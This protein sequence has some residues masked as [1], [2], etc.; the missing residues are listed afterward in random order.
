M[1]HLHQM[2]NKMLLMGI[3]S[4]WPEHAHLQNLA[5][6]IWIESESV[7]SV[8]VVTDLVAGEVATGSEH[9]SSFQMQL[10]L[11]K[12]Q[13]WD[14]YLYYDH[15]SSSLNLRWKTCRHCY[16]GQLHY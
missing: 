13:Y 1:Q 4:L 5:I 2:V 11:E 6:V 9:E 7:I 10:T 3:E 16:Y 12:A 14:V 15:F 8:V